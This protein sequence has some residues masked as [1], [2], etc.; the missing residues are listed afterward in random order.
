M[1]YWVSV[2]SLKIPFNFGAMAS[3]KIKF[4]SHRERERERERDACRRL[5]NWILKIRESVLER[6]EG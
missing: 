3:R 1:P 2:H 6:F 4:S 5:Q